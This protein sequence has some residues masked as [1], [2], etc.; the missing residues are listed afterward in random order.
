M[1]AF[2]ASMALVSRQSHCWMKISTIVKSILDG[3]DDHIPTEFNGISCFI[4]REVNPESNVRVDG[5]E[6]NILYIPE[7]IHKA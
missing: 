2:F 4:A 1:I 5:K 3:T 7:K 6:G